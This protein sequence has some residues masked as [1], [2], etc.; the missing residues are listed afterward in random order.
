MKYQTIF[1]VLLGL[2][3]AY[4]GLASLGASGNYSH[5]F[6]AMACVALAGWFGWMIRDCSGQ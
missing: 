2:L 6:H 1:S 5:A 4:W 3:T